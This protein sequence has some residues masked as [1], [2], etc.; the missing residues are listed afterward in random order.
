MSGGTALPECVERGASDAA[1]AA[2]IWLHGLGADGHDFEPLVGQLRLPPVPAIRFVFPHAPVRPVTLNGGARMR[3][4]YDLTP[5]GPGWREDEAGIVA[6]GRTV[7]ALIEREID[8]GVPAGRVV[9]G[10][11]SQGGALALYSALRHPERL[12]G[13]AVLSAYL[14]LAGRLDAEAAAAN[15]DL[16]LFVAHGG[17]DPVIDPEIAARSC[18]RLRE[19][20]YAP[21]WHLYDM[22]HTVCPE[23]VR[24]LRAWLLGEALAGP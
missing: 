20:G 5:P 22:A 8:R 18:R 12:A 9:L 10:G 15:R 4:W 11:F 21:Q 3:A 1:D 19:L 13:A 24:D 14:P 23:E 2:V 16:A 7:R 17:A 6:A